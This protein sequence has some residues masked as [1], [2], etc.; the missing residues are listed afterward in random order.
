VT[1]LS[2]HK[3]VMA[4]DGEPLDQS[5]AGLDPGVRICRCQPESGSG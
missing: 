1:A 2:A 3:S 5:E 4:T